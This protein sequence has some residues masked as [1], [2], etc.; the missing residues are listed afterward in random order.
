VFLKTL[1][2]VPLS[3]APSGFELTVMPAR[4]R[5]VIPKSMIC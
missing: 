1:N 3:L 5:I 2:P 4:K